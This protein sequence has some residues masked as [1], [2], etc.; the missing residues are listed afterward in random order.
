MHRYALRR[1]WGPSVVV[2]FIHDHHLMCTQS[3]QAQDIPV[4]AWS[5]CFT[6]HVTHWACLGCSGSAYAT[7]WKTEYF[8]L[9]FYCGPASGTWHTCANIIF[10]SQLSE[11]QMFC[12]FLIPAVRKYLTVI[13]CAVTCCQTWSWMLFALVFLQWLTC[14]YM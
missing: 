3:L 10:S 11:C 14:F 12:L 6:T 8:R 9:A 2:Q 1:S 13:M 7:V 5:A 4:L